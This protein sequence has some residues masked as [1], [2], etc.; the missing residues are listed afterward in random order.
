MATE[1]GASS[2]KKAQKVEIG[3]LWDTPSPRGVAEE[4][5][6]LV[7]RA[8]TCP[9]PLFVGGRRL[10]NLLPDPPE[11]PTVFSGK[12]KEFRCPMSIGIS[13][14]Q[15]PPLRAFKSPESITGTQKKW[16]I[17]DRF[18]NSTPV[19]QDEVKLEYCQKY[20]RLDFTFKATFWESNHTAGRYNWNLKFNHDVPFVKSHVHWVLD[21]VVVTSEELGTKQKGVSLHLYLSAADLE[22]DLSGFGISYKESEER[23]S[24]V[25]AALKGFSTEIE[26]TRLSLRKIIPGPFMASAAP[27]FSFFGIHGMFFLKL[28]P[29]YLAIGAYAGVRSAKEKKR[30]IK[31]CGAALESFQQNLS[32]SY[33]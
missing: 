5:Q 28:F 12:P 27:V 17:G 8:Y 20:W 9:I 24:R 3:V 32:Q 15:G 18:T 4:Y 31:E 26:K 33:D 21:G 23:E 13:P 6:A 29:L 30:V 25:K 19:H 11:K 22:L 1:T 14:D 2:W 10:D 7:G 16:S